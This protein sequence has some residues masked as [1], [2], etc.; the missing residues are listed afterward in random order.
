ML[1]QMRLP[2]QSSP[3]PDAADPLRYELMQEMAFSLGRAGRRLQALLDKLAQDRSPDQR[4]ELVR[5]AGEALWYYVVQ[6]E[7]C[8]LR[9]TD[10]LMER[11]GVPSEVRLRMGCR[12][13]GSPI[14]LPSDKRRE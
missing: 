14:V 5:Q 11:L 1:L 8:G 4:D 12:P 9:D 10:D 6:R 3:P 2:S 7:A 13:P